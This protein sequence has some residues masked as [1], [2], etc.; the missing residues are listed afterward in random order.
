MRSEANERRL[1]NE[2]NLVRFVVVQH[3]GMTKARTEVLER[4]EYGVLR[5][6]T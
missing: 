6:T 2:I 3:A 4:V 1:Q 5:R